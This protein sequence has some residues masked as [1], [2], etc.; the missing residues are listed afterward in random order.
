MT[1]KA[2]TRLA[3]ALIGVGIVLRLGFLGADSLWLDEAYSVV[4]VQEH[5]LREAW[6]TV[7]DRD[8]PPL[9][10]VLLRLSVYAF[11][12]SETTARLPSALASVCGLGLIFVLARRLGL[13]TRAGLAAVL[14]LALAPVDVWYAQEARMYALVTM[15]GLLFAI[16]LAME[17]PAGA[18]L[19]AI[20][21][22]AGLYADFTM[23]PLSAALT[24]VW[25]VRWWHLGRPPWLLARVIIATSAAWWAYRPQWTHLWEILSRIDTVPLFVNLRDASL[26]RLAPGWPALAVATLLVIGTLTATAVMWRALANHRVRTWSTWIAWSGFMAYT[27]AVMIPRAYSAKQFISTGWPFVILAV[28]WSLTDGGREEDGPAPAARLA[29]LRL[30]LAAG[31]SL[32]AAIVVVA[33]PR[34][35]WRGVVASLNARAASARPGT[36][37]VWLDPVWNYTAYD[38]YRPTIAAV[39]DPLPSAEASRGPRAP[40][41]DVC[42][43]AERFGRTPPT[44]Q[45][46]VWL[47]N[48][49]R[50][51]DVVPF[52]RLE[53]RCYTNREAA[54]GLPAIHH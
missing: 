31:L 18:L 47:D 3:L 39:P 48:H 46:E 21:L 12:A 5:T 52:A 29:R 20:A 30:P 37:A 50:L 36:L 43:V 11:G 6:E 15:F 7:L 27:A 23:V 44:S 9:F 13:S 26:L 33:A 34:A 51:V 49:L 32:V 14:L 24:A 54:T 10:F 2:A 1:T 35:D 4:V 28:V 41:S 53:L 19:A 25:L 16:G 42:L 40:V 45:S 8:H 22:A 38:Y 17:S